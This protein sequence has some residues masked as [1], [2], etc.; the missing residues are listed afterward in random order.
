M[1]HASLVQT[2]QSMLYQIALTGLYKNL[3]ALIEEGKAFSW[4]QLIIESLTFKTMEKR[5]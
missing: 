3:G 1:E 2:E 5:F 4:R